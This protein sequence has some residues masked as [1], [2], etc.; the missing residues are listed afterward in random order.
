MQPPDR[1]A[2]PHPATDAAPDADAV[3]AALAQVPYAG[4]TR[5]LVSLGMVRHVSACDGRVKVQLGLRTADPTVPERLE[6]AIG[7]RLAALGAREVA[8]VIGEPAPPAA[9]PPR[10]GNDPWADQVRL[11][12]VRHVVA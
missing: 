9:M 3:R 6:R 5:D 10:Q 12:A 7:E 11:A 8:V 2:P 1:T 4:L